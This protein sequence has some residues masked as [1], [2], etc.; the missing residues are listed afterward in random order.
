[1]LVITAVAPA[2]IS[3]PIRPIKPEDVA[4]MQSQSKIQYCACAAGLCLYMIFPMI[5]VPPMLML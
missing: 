4:T 1:M 2:D 5:S 3:R